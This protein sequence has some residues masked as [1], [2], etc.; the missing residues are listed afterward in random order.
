MQNR[1]THVRSLM[2]GLTWRAL[3]TLTTVVIAW[4]VVGDVAVA[5]EIGAI[6]VVAK[7]VI[8]SCMSGRGSG[9]RAGMHRRWWQRARRSK[10]ANLCSALVEVRSQLVRKPVLHPQELSLAV[11]QQVQP[12]LLELMM[13]IALEAHPRVDAVVPEHG[14]PVPR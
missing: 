1:D 11:C 4:I 6:E 3:A 13:R 7:I 14:M 8:D 2:K 9:Y 10:R 12:G 5:L